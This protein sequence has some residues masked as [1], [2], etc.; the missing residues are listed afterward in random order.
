MAKRIKT[1]GAKHP[2]HP[3][4]VRCGSEKGHVEAE[5]F[6][7]FYMRSWDDDDARPT[8]EARNAR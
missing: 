7:S 6:N 5:H 4:Q 2:M 8:K 3:A 1:C